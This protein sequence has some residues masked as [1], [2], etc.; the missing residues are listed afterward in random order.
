MESGIVVLLRDR[1][2]G[3]GGKVERSRNILSLQLNNSQTPIYFSF[4]IIQYTSNDL[5]RSHLRLRDF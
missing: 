4:Y 1:L 5:F 2:K 3:A